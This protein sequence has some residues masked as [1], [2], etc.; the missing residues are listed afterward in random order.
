MFENKIQT[1][2]FEIVALSSWLQ[3]ILFFSFF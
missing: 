1:K 3:F 2:H